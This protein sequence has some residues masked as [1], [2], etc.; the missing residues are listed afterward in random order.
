M[1]KTEKTEKLRALLEHVI[2]SH[3]SFMVDISVRGE[4]RR[5]LLELFCE[6]DKGITVSECAE[7]SRGVLP[8]VEASGIL[9][10]S[11][12]LE[13]SS[14]GVG[15][16]LKNRRQYRSNIGRSMSVTYR[17]GEEVRNAEGDLVGLTEDKITLRTDTASIEL[18]FDSIL[19]ARV[20]IR[21]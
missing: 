5:Q 8:I 2:E 19:E 9:G 14:P 17:E 10:D 18:A 3:G 20:K 11:F 21:W 6:T 7:I 16:P 1:D 13:V 4:G 15:V 12:R